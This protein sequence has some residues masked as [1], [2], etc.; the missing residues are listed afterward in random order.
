MSSPNGNTEDVGDRGL[1]DSFAA[2]TSLESQQGS[3]AASFRGRNTTKTT[4]ELKKARESRAAEALRMK[5]EQLRI[6]A[7]QNAKLLASLDKVCYSHYAR[8]Y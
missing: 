3:M 1:E 6:L 8:M 7:E 4:D 2:S 5:D